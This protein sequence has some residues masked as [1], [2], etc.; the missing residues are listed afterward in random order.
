[1]VIK[2]Y[3]NDAQLTD[4]LHESNANELLIEHPNIVKAERHVWH[5]SIKGPL[6]IRGGLF[7][8]YSYI[9]MPYFE[10]GS[11]LDLIMKAAQI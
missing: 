8:S 7:D 9:T 6:R 10:K 5:E 1:M 4:F 3:V 11:L 2:G